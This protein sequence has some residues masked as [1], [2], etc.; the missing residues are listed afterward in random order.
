M[1]SGYLQCA[2]TI[3]GLARQCGIAWVGARLSNHAGPAALYARMPL[4]QDMIEAA[5]PVLHVYGLS[6]ADIGR[7]VDASLSQGHVA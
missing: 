4:A 3:A 7:E 1:R 2:D 6:P 5:S